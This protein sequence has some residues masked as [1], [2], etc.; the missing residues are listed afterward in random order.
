MPLYMD[1]HNV[2]SDNFTVEDVV[3]AH[4]EDLAVEEKFGVTQHKY[5]VNQQRRDKMLKPHNISSPKPRNRG[6]T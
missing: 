1:I 6:V 5:W 2:D 3:K 4:M